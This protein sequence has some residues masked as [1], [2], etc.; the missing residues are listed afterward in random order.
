MV[1]VGESAVEEVAGEAE[2]AADWIVAKETLLPPAA[3]AVPFS[4]MEEGVVGH[5]SSIILLLMRDDLVLDSLA[6]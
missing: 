1:A 2:E 4:L 5:T 6:R 3:A